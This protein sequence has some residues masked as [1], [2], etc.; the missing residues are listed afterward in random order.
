MKKS[1]NSEN[2]F[3]WDDPLALFAKWMET[4]E[5]AEPK[6]ANAMAL[7]TVDASG[8]PDVRMVLLKQFGPDGF[9]FFS[10]KN[11]AKGKQLKQNPQVALGLYWKSL[12]RQVRIRGTVKPLARKDVALY[13]DSRPKM[14]RIG[15]WA[16]K[17]SEEMKTDTAFKSALKHVKQ[18]FKNTKIPLPP[19]WGGW[20]VEPLSIEF[21]QEKP[22]R[23]HDRLLF[24]YNIKTKTWTKR[25]LYP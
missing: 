15:A 2:M 12:G 4:A 13:F 20:R 18:K 10:H 23:L 6:D 7:A 25:R 3:V 8:L 17:Q 21:W 1:K 19:G 9:V 11:S 16:S 22:F 14:S 24:E 5:D